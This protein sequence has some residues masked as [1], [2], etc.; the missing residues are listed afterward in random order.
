MNPVPVLVAEDEA[1]LRQ[2]LVRLLEAAWPDCQV[3]AAC[4]D[5]Q[6]AITRFEQLRPRVCFLDIRMPGASGLDV[7]RQ[8]DERAHVVFVTAYDEF[9][10]DAFERGAVGYLLKPVDPLKLAAVV[11]RVCRG[12]ERR[13]AKLDALVGRIQQGAHGV[14]GWEPLRWITA[15]A[16]DTV[17]FFPIEEALA[18]VSKDKCT[19]LLTAGQDAIIRASLRELSARLDPA[20]FWRVHRSVLVRASAIESIRQRAGRHELSLK[21]RTERLPVSSSFRARVKAM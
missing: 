16:G 6:E 13:P 10:I 2:E 3:V 19:Q 8:I 18:F 7:A 20:Q 15:S 14:S 1:P 5:G 9:A 12:L 21:G 4:A 11:A 17:R